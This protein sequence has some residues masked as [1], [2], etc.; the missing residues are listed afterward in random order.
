MSDTHVVN[1]DSGA[2]SQEV[3]AQDLKELAAETAP[4]L[5]VVTGDL[6]NMGTVPE[7]ESYRAAIESVPIPVF[8]VFGGHDGNIERRST[9]ADTP[10][11]RNFEATLGPTYY[12]FDWGGYHFVIYATEESYYSAADRARK[13]RW[14]V[15]DLALQP[16]DRQSVLM[17][18]T[19]PDEGLLAK[20]SGHN[21][22]LGPPRPLALQQSLQYRRDC[23][24]LILVILLWR[25]RHAAAG[26][27]SRFVF[28]ARNPDGIA[29]SGSHSQRQERIT[30]CDPPATCQP[31]ASTCD[32]WA[33]RPSPLLGNT[34][35]R[36]RCIARRRSISKGSVLSQPAE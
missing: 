15:A 29:C 8:S 27:S 34:N 21:G 36:A 13:E 19:A 4:D 11:T 7:L 31:S 5:V 20:F 32:A 30:L 1:D 25:H 10:C 17:L 16:S 24:C 28:S 18:H 22:A 9:A 23:C 35:S 33:N 26:M 2:V 3:L 14:L 12:S 6:T